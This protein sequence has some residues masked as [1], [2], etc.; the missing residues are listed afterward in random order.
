MRK[1]FYKLFWYDYNGILHTEVG[2]LF[3]GEDSPEHREDDIV[4]YVG[5]WDE[6][7]KLQLNE[8]G[9]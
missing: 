9:R 3:D 1:Q 6:A 4:K 2:W 5:T 7:I 8:F